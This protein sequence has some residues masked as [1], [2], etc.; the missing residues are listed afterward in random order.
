MNQIIQIL[1]L[2]TVL[3]IINLTLASVCVT[4]L[5]AT[6]QTDMTMNK[7]T[8]LV[9]DLSQSGIPLTPFWKSTGYSPGPI[10]LRDD[11]Q[12]TLDWIG[13]MA[14]N[15]I[16]YIRPHYMLDLIAVEGI[17]TEFPKY[18][19]TRL[20]KVLDAHVQNDLKMI[21]ELMG[22]PST[23]LDKLGGIYDDAF[24]K[25]KSGAPSFFSDFSTDE[26][27]HAWKR[28][29]RDLARHCINRYGAEVVRSWYFETWNEPNHPKFWPHGIEAFKN[30]YDACSEGLKEADPE[31]RL[32]G[33]GT[34]GR[35]GPGSWGVKIVEHAVNG[36]NYFT[37]EEGTRMDFISFHIKALPDEMLLKTEMSQETLA[38]FPD[39]KGTPIFNDES[40]PFWGW[41][42][43]YWWRRGPWYAAC[44]ARA[45][46]LHQNAGI[47]LDAFPYTIMSNDNA[48]MGSWG[49][50]VLHTRFEDSDREGFSMVKKPAH[51]LMSL[52]GRLPMGESIA[53]PFTGPEAEVLDGF[54]IK[55]SREVNIV[56][57]QLPAVPEYQK[58]EQLDPTP[59]Q[60]A[61]L[62][63]TRNKVSIDLLNLNF[64]EPRLLIYAIDETHGNPFKVWDKAGRPETPSPEQ[65]QA[66]RAHEEPAL[67]TDENLTIEE[68]ATQ[69]TFDLDGSATRVIRILEKPADAPN[70]PESL[71]SRIF[72]GLHGPEALVKWQ[73]PGCTSS[74]KTYEVFFSPV[75]SDPGEKISSVDFF[76]TAFLWAP[77][78]LPEDGWLRVRA[79]DYWG[80]TSEPSEPLQFP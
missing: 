57:T 53:L 10:A 21:F 48:F 15:G 70:T 14:G 13:A 22:Y 6:E 58:H 63:A 34:V 45:I 76:D 80:R 73:L 2:R 39:L 30:Y 31:I 7:S 55:S 4:Q 32:G 47:T 33:P 78:E 46:T 54:V 12:Q 25:R 24:Q 75:K 5:A 67:L 52:L 72:L 69:L 42:K 23:D 66:M 38:A 11:M 27:L 44:M 68:G 60:A 59:E 9:V 77:T 17:E 37:G 71:S 41:S 1:P 8:Q 19:W 16:E 61:V 43:T 65:L 18:N 50:R 29:V 26:Q 28:L 79:V 51:M 49:N 36:T 74:I 62:D 56:L 3:F 35:L 64:K 40:D 20:N